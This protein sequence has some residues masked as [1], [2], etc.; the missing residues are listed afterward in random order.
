MSGKNDSVQEGAEVGKPIRFVPSSH[1]EPRRKKAHKKSRGGCAACKRRKVKCDERI[2]CTNCVRR[3]ESCDPTQ[4]LQSPEASSPAVNDPAGPVN[5][6]HMELFHHFQ[7]SAVP[8]L[9]FKQTWPTAI[10]L[11]FEEECLMTAILAVSARHL[12]ITQPEK[13]SYAQAAMSLLSRSCAAF[14]VLLDQ[15]DSREMSDA[16]FFTA[17]SIHYLTWCNVDFINNQDRVADH[18]VHLRVDL[19]EDKLYSLS[20]G[21]RVF[22]SGTRARGSDSI[23][24]RMSSINQC[25]A[26]QT[27]F[28]T[29][30]L[31]CESVA[32]RW[33][34]RYDEL[35]LRVN[36]EQR[37]AFSRIAHHLA[38]IL[39]LWD[40]RHS[41]PTPP[42]REDIER[43]IFSFP[44]FCIKTFLDMIT[45]GDSRAFLVL[46][47]F[48]RTSRLLLGQERCWWASERLEVMEALI[49]E[50]LGRRDV[51][52]AL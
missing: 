9:C 34:E 51:A 32:Q 12:S 5:L 7:E 41:N 42:Q 48:Y 28:K 3:N 21:V 31:D 6:L 37:E 44:L 43:Y 18:P 26:L 46:Y 16:L 33:M 20:P 22:L 27:I 10:P 17:M 39:A 30:N 45:S 40:H 1:L 19:S 23:F 14:S 24:T 36:H 38:V 8:T 2:P 29:Q 47:H 52:L 11:A 15:E 49:G 50:E 4:K 25:G 35:T 13:R